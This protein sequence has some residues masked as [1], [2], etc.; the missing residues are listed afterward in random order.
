MHQA[1]QTAQRL[2][3]H[4]ISRETCE[5]LR[6]HKAVIMDVLPAALTS[7]Y[8]HVALFPETKAFFRN[9]EHMAHARTMQL[10]HWDTITDGTF[11]ETYDSSVARIGETHNRLGLEP[12]WYIGAY[13]FLLTRLVDALDHKMADGFL[14]RSKTST[15]RIRIQAAVIQAAM[16]D[17]D[18]AISIYMEAGRRERRA[19]L[20]N[21]GKTFEDSIGG[22]VAL[23]STAAME[24]QTTAQTMTATADETASQ[25]R[26]VAS[27]SEEAS[28]N[29]RAVAA[30][31]EE[32]SVSV[33]GIGGQVGESA[34]IA[35]TA[36]RSAEATVEKV[37]RLSK[38]AHKI[39]DIV[40]LINTIASQTNLLALNATIEAARAGEA[41]KGFAVVAQE[42]KSLAAQTAKA[43]AGIS[44]QITD[45]Q[46][47]TAESE[48]SIGEIS[49][50]IHQMHE[51]SLAISTSVD[52]Q[53]SAI[54]EIARNVQEASQGTMEVTANISC[55][56]R[57]VADTGAAAAQVLAGASAL[58]RQAGT[59]Q[60]EVQAF[61]SK[62]ASA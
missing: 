38:A 46:G 32:M 30:A 44:S 36:V 7:F 11:D 39:G 20:D 12:R 21:L 45:I 41:G 53:T 3:F 19:T 23:V 52:Q 40:E 48:R 6:R 60:T 10:R 56:T 57:A 62:V 49:T 29:V 43:T 14:G 1:T 47:A 42:V 2:A 50:V 5:V 59:L 18:V 27:A 16:L 8:E 9:P 13:S 34:R 55:V 51:I 37:E 35:V 4:R 31:T 24:M 61:L 54:G 33:R 58:S 17:M 28:T 15:E 22:I 25:S 26:V